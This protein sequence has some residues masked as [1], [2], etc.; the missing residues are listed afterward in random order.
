MHPKA[1]RNKA[2]ILCVISD[3]SEILNR[4]D[5]NMRRIAYN[6]TGYRH[7]DWSN[8]SLMSRYMYTL[9]KSAR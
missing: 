5:E 2:N 4:L 7:R 8:F 9:T 1:Y 3:L 6:Y